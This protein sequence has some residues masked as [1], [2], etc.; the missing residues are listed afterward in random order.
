LEKEEDVDYQPYS[1]IVAANGMV[2]AEDAVAAIERQY[3]TGG[4][5]VR[6]TPDIAD[7]VYE[8]LAEAHPHLFKKLGRMSVIARVIIDS[9]RRHEAVPEPLEAASEPAPAH[10]LADDKAAAERA[11]QQTEAS[12]AEKA[13][14]RIRALRSQF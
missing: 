7:S 2:N 3:S 11:R 1:V 8:H 5:R 12:A 10:R 14:A 9:H 4:N 6:I 13:A